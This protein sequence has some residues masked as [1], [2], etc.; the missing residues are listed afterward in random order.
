MANAALI[1]YVS[2]LRYG[3]L[4]GG[5]WILVAFISMCLA[6]VLTVVGLFSAFYALI[7]K[8]PSGLLP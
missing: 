2:T 4:E 5:E 3:G 8:Q 6:P 1:F 7:G